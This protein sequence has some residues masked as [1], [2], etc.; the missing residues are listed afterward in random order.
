MTLTRPP[1][2]YFFFATLIAL[3][4]YASISQA[5]PREDAD[6][7]A[8]Q[9]VTRELFEAAIEAER[10]TI[11]SA[12][13]FDLQSKGV[14]LP[15]PDRFLDL[16]ME[17]FIDGFT[18]TMQNET[19]NLYVSRFSEQDLADIAAFYRTQAG[20]ALINQ[21]PDLI[22]EGSRIG[23]IAGQ[24]AGKNLGKRLAA[25]IKS[26]GLIE[27]DDPNLLSRLIDALK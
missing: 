16:I 22:L 18:E 15:N 14:K 17:E 9:T 25:R 1:A 7:I 27:V 11:V 3:S 10:T 23:R 13:Q 6:Y 26:E 12:I 8:E 5:A 2:R 4:G 20:Q 21:T 24:R 19:A